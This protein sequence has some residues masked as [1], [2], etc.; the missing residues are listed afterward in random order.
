MMVVDQHAVAL[1]LCHQHIKHVQFWNS[2]KK[3]VYRFF[4]IINTPFSNTVLA[5]RILT[6]DE[7]KNTLFLVIVIA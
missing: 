5:V 2:K 3:T 7:F 4:I 1:S 6:F